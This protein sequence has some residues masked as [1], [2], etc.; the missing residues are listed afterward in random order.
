ME[1]NVDVLLI[2]EHR[3]VNVPMARAQITDISKGWP[4]V[5]EPQ[6]PMEHTEEVEEW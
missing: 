2:Q 6:K 3:L 5:W 1:R 4:G